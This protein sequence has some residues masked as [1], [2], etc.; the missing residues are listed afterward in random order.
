MGL[1][2]ATVTGFARDDLSD[3]GAWLSATTVRAFKE[4]NPSTRVEP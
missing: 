1:R 4:L 2:G 3:G